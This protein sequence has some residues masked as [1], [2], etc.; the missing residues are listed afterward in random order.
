MGHLK[1]RAQ[2]ACLEDLM[3]VTRGAGLAAIVSCEVTEHRNSQ[4]VP[5]DGHTAPTGPGQPSP[6]NPTALRTGEEIW[7]LNMQLAAQAEALGEPESPRP[8]KRRKPTLAEHLREK[9]WGG[10]VPIPSAA[11]SQQLMGQQPEP[12][13]LPSEATTDDALARAEVTAAPPVAPPHQAPPQRR[14]KL[15]I[16][17]P[18]GLVAKATVDTAVPLPVQQQPTLP[19]GV[20]PGVLSQLL[21][22]RSPAVMQHQGQQ[23]PRQ[24]QCPLHADVADAAAGGVVGAEESAGGVAPD[25]AEGAGGAEAPGG[26]ANADAVQQL[27][28]TEALPQSGGALAV[29]QQTGQAQR[30]AQQQ[31]NADVAAA[32]AGGTEGAGGVAAADLFLARPGLQLGLVRAGLQRLYGPQ[33]AT[34]TAMLHGAGEAAGGVAPDGA[35]GAGGAE[36]PGGAANADAVQQLGVTEALP[37]SGGALAVLQQTGQAQRQAQQQLNADVAAAAAGGTE[38]AGVVAAADLFLARPGLQLGLARAGLQRLY[39]PQPATYTAMLHGAG[40]A[41]GGVAPDGAEGAGGAEAPGGAA[42]A[43]AVQQ[44]GVTEA[45]PQSGGALAVLQQTGQAQRQAQQQL[46]AD[47]AAAAAGGT[48]GAG[49]VAAADLFLAR[50]GLQLGLVRAGLQRLYGPQPATYTAMLHGAGEAAGGVAP[51]GAEGAGGAEAPGGAANADAVQQLGVTEALPQSGGALA[52]LQQTGQAQR[53][54]QQQLNADVAAAAAGGTEGAGGV[55]AADLFLARP[56]LQLGLARAGLQRL[57]GP[58]PATYTAMLHGAGE[59]AGGV[60]PDGA[61]GA[62][63]AEAPGGAA[64][65]DAVQQLGVTEALPQSGGALAVLQQTGQAQRQAQQQL[66]ADVAAAAAGGTEGAGVVAAADLFLARPGLQL[67]LARAGLQR[68][69]GPQPATYTAMLHGAGEAAGGVAP[70]GAEGAGGAEAPGGAANADAVQQLGVTEAL[71]QSGGALAVLQQTG[72]AQRQAQQQLNADVAAAA[73]GGTEGAGGVAA[74]DLFLARP[75]LQLGLALS[76]VFAWALRCTRGAARARQPVEHRH[77]AKSKPNRDLEAPSHAPYWC[78]CLGTR[79]QQG[80]SGLSWRIAEWR[81]CLGATLHKG[82]RQ[83]AA[84]C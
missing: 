22:L 56:G 8:T 26:A 21:A 10:K 70:D 4:A 29:L 61:E 72:Q 31:L 59:A 45:L 60:A 48:E 2:T 27:G 5:G 80:D 78:S 84:A 7:Q 13:L 41:A 20:R 24:Q 35:E 77:V 55:A 67:G 74:A 42:N 12:Q 51:D 81:V 54:A 46:N 1:T 16:R 76:G 40:E 47:V 50:P 62:G 33:P 64:N 75:G 11:A 49:G 44:L 32:A 53:Q 69:Y 57:Y 43:D 68:L 14:I 65:A 19:T 36:A 73:A 37:Q 38:G 6:A 79:T 25:G 18:G 9:C 52:V 3:S 63:G 82:S 28:V 71:P 17:L 83:S 58:Q 66:N 23:Q 39:G 34:Y 30:Q 15:G